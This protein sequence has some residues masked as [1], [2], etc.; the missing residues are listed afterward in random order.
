MDQVTTLADDV[1]DGLTRPFK[2][3]PPKHFYDARGS[4]L[5][6]AICALPEYYPTRTERSILVDRGEE[7]LARAQSVELVEL[8]AGSAAKTRVL[9]DTGR[10]RR[11]VAFDVSGT[12][13]DEDALAAEY[14]RIEILHVTGDFERDLD[15]VPAPETGEPRLL[16]FLGGT[17]GNFMPGARRT[18]LRTLA[19]AL[20][21]DDAL[22]LGAGLITDVDVMEAAYDDAAGVTAAFNLNLLEV[23]NRELGGNFDLDRF[24]HVAFFDSQNEWIEM[25]LRARRDHTVQLTALDFEV[26]FKRGE[27][28]RTELSTKFT[29]ARLEA[30]YAAAG[31]R[32]DGW[33]SDAADRFALSLARP[34]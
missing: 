29:R 4:E 25:R 15:R 14:P 6:E 11:Y 21:P 30:D 20:G 27:E 7:I 1:M 18:F 31:L 23:L 17:I 8:G 5:F 13:L 12:A 28:M 24:E 19:G 22:L 9:L 2:E 3:L 16:A 32:L 33:Y 10:I 26:R 34:D